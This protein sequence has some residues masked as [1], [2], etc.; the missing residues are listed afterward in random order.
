MGISYYEGEDI[1]E[2]GY[3]A[4]RERPSFRV[5]FTLLL[6]A[7]FLLY[8]FD[9]LYQR[10]MPRRLDKKWSQ[11]YDLLGGGSANDNNN[12]NNYNEHEIEKMH[13]R[14]EAE[15]LRERLKLYEAE[16]KRRNEGVNKKKKNSERSMEGKRKKMVYSYV[17]IWII[18]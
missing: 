17:I 12:N 16:E 14:M 2:V 4:Y 5:I 7:F 11:K 13:L 10:P 15:T 9:W 8:A 1:E 18:P 3:N 6:I